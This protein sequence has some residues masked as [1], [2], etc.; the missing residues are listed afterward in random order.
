MRA[1]YRLIRRGTRGGGF[2]CVD[3]ETGKRNSL[4]TA[5]ENEARQIIEAKNQ[6]T[7]QPAINMQIAQAYLQHAD[8]A[9]SARTWQECDGAN[10]FDQDGKH[11]GTVDLCD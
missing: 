3:A 2:Y 8:P 10:H 6:A 1:R 11:P 9:L 5:N 4:H 7:R